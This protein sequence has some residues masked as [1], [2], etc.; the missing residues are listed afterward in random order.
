LNELGSASFKSYLIEDKENI[1]FSID[2]FLKS[3]RQRWPLSY[4]AEGFHSQLINAGLSSGVLDFVELSVNGRPIAWRLVFRFNKTVIFYMPALDEDYS[5]YSPG[6]LTQSWV[7]GNSAEGGFVHVDHLRGG[8]EYKAIWGGEETM[9]F[10]VKIA[11]NSN[12]GGWLRKAIY[13]LFSKL[14]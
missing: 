9:I 6:L 5:K 3:H 14:E 11:G 13:A 4:K 7:L 12:I 2:L 10:D 1:N 8:E